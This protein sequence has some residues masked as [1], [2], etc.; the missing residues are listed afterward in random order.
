MQFCNKC[1]CT[2]II[3]L[4]CHIQHSPLCI[5]FIISEIGIFVINFDG[6]ILIK[7][8]LTVKRLGQ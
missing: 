4:F 7:S 5:N 6:E 1:T 2:V 8:L 3:Y